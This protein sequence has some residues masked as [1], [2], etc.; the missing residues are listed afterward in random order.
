MSFENS[1][2][3]LVLQSNRKPPSPAASLCHVGHLRLKDT[4]L[5]HKVIHKS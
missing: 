4:Q 1:T 3:K 5:I 2:F